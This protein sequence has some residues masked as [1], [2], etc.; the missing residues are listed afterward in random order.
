[1]IALM[2]QLASVTMPMNLEIFQKAV[3]MPGSNLELRLV[4]RAANIVCY[5]DRDFSRLCID[6]NPEKKQ[7]LEQFNRIK[8]FPFTYQHQT[9]PV[10]RSGGLQVLLFTVWGLALAAAVI[11]SAKVWQTSGL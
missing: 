8:F 7:Y 5:V 10:E 6:R 9:P 4:Q 2:V 11:T 1:M 3:G